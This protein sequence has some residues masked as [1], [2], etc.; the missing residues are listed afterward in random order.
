MLADQI[1]V[2]AQIIGYRGSAPVITDLIGG[3]LGIAIDTLDVLMRQ[4]QGDRIRI[5]ATSGEERE[6]ALPDV[7]TF[8]ESGL[9]LQAHGW[10]AFFAPAAMTPEKVQF[11]GETIKEIVAQDNVQELMLQSDMIPVM[12]TASESAEIITAFQQQWAP[13]IKASGYVVDK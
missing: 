1:G 13:V 8:T 6:T 4:H 12:T 5:L 10:N 2:D 7:P 9:D 3:T 11:L